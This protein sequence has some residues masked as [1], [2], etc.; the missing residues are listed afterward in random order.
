MNVSDEDFG[1]LQ[2]HRLRWRLSEGMRAY[3]CAAFV[4]EAAED[5]NGRPKKGFVLVKRSVV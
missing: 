5:G 4:D 1:R 3:I 2:V